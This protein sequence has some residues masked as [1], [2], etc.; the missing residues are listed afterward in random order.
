MSNVTKDQVIEW[1]SGE[2][3]IDLAAPVKDLEAKGGVS[4]AAQTD[5]RPGRGR[6]CKAG[7]LASTGR[8]RGGA[9]R[10]RRPFR[11]I[12]KIRWRSCSRGR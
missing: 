12:S 9:S 2:T 6:G 1:H 5:R 10:S 3:V 11:K 8:S 4:D 7:G